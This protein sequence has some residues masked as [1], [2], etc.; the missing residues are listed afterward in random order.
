MHQS[1]LPRLTL[2]IAAAPRLRALAHRMLGSFSDADD[3][4]QDAWLRWS[5]IDPAAITAPEAFLTTLVSRLAVDR[6]RAARRTREAYFGQW[7]PEPALLSDA[8]TAL[9]GEA[10]VAFMLLLERL[11]PEQ[12]AVYVL[13]EAMEMEYGE[14]AVILEKTAPACRQLMR[15]AKEGLSGPARFAID[16]EHSRQVADSFAK[17]SLARDYSAIV[18]LLNEHAVLL[19]DGGGMA[20]S[21]INPIYGA[22]RIARFFIGV[23]NKLKGPLGFEAANINGVPGFITRVGGQMHGALVFDMAEGRITRAFLIVNPEKLA[24]LGL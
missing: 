12:R 8:E 3:V 9:P 2:F 17:A 16:R 19:A 23:Q 24:H 4:L 18:A 14:I 5:G 7:L 21:A 11:T 6:L 20:R 22:D 1:D 10:S 15:R 13:R